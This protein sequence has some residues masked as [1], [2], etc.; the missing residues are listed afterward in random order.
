MLGFLQSREF[1]ERKMEAWGWKKSWSHVGSPFQSR[2][3]RGGVI[4][5]SSKLS[6]W[7]NRGDN[8]RDFWSVV[9]TIRSR[10]SGRTPA[11]GSREK[12]PKTKP[13][14]FWGPKSEEW[15]ER[16]WFHVW[17]SANQ[18][19]SSLRGNY[20][21]WE[22][23][24]EWPGS[25]TTKQMGQP[26][27][28]RMDIWWCVCWGTRK[29]P[30]RC[31]QNQGMCVSKGCVFRDWKGQPR[32]GKAVHQQPRAF[33]VDSTPKV[34]SRLHAHRAVSSVKKSL[35]VKSLKK[36]KTGTSLVVQWLRLLAPKQKAQVHSL[37]REL[38][39]TCCN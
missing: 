4:L 9:N 2:S 27:T 20:C 5:E 3:E 34:S 31:L 24:S 8:E 28:K 1:P 6:L 36:I 11:K 37:A 21:A 25:S 35:D 17:V 18:L 15:I 13:L 16:K 10:D 39:P 33:G 7:Q 22:S 30:C 32:G 26:E 14:T 12:W 38:E 19:S 23:D 29:A